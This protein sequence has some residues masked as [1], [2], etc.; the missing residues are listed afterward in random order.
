MTEHKEQYLFLL[1][2]DSILV[3]E[4]TQLPPLRHL[5]DL[6]LAH[7]QL[8][9]NPI[10]QNTSECDYWG[11]WPIHEEPPEGYLFVGLRGFAQSAPY[12]IFM[13]AG[14]AYQLMNWIKNSQFC[15]R[16]S[17]PLHFHETERARTCKECGFLLYPTLSPAIIVAVQKGNLLLLARSPHFRPGMVSVLAGFVEMGE[18]LE[19]TVRREVFE[20]VGVRV[21]NVRYF[22]SQPWPFPHS[23][24][25]GFTAEWESGEIQVDGIEIESAGWY[26]VDNTPP[27]PSSVSIASQLIENW[28]K[29]VSRK[30][31][32]SPQK[33]P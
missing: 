2:N 13:R 32:H 12:S 11:S 16:C 6:V 9:I 24:M 26:S 33:R 23:L 29:R 27:L 19:D 20:E 14:I 17:S 8:S 28:K 7:V 21:K 30:K 10:E 5:H 15:G 4:Q 31:T 22:G 3:N 1:K 18:T 25:L